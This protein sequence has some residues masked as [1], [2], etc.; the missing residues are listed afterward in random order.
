MSEQDPV[1][2][3]NP[4]VDG[5]EH[6][7]H[8]LHEGETGLVDGLPK[9]IVAVENAPTVVADTKAVIANVTLLKPLITA[10][11]AAIATGGT[12]ISNDAGV[13]SALEAAVPVFEKITTSV[14]TLSQA[15]SA[16]VKQAEA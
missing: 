8:W 4:I 15:V 16:A 11:G 3:K 13:I 12:N 1:Y 10:I 7:G 9:V 5:I 2:S 14:E 6:V